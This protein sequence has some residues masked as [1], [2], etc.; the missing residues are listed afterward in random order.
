MDLD[1][2]ETSFDLVAPRGDELMEIFYANL[3]AAAPAVTPLF[4]H[5]DMARQ[6]QMLLAALVLLRNSLRNLETVV[7]TLRKLGA[8]HAAYGAEAGHYPVVGQAL[9]AAMAEVAGNDWDES[10]AEA[11][12]VAFGVV[13]GA[14]LDGAAAELQLAA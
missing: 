6:R 3:F 13:A 8:R 12:G 4:A 10:Y 1:A 7:P 14:M 5:T 11:W 9:I 2:L